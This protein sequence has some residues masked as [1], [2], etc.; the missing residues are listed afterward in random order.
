MISNNIKYLKIN[1]KLINFGKLLIKHLFY[2]KIHNV[3]FNLIIG[4]R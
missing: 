1:Q 4:R 2:D 3:L